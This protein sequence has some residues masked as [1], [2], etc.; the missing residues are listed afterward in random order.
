LRD[1]REAPDVIASSL[2]VRM[3]GLQ[4]VPC[5]VVV[6]T[7]AGADARIEVGSDGLSGQSPPAGV[8]TADVVEVA[9]IP[10]QSGRPGHVGQA[11]G[12]ADSTALLLVVSAYLE[13]MDDGVIG[14]PD[15][16]EAQYLDGTD[17][18]PSL[19]GAVVGAKRTDRVGEA[20]RLRSRDGQWSKEIQIETVGPLHMRADI[21]AVQWVRVGR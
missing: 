14:I 1:E 2:V 6:T 15:V 21:D 19:L 17:A 11:A 18:L 9:G 20:V 13:P 7:T 3:T 5:A 8:V 16:V 4:T 10:T 12:N